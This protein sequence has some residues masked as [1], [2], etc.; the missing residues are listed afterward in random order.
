MSIRRDAADQ[1]GF[2]MLEVLIATM[3]MVTILLALATVTAQWMPNW[4]RGMARVQQLERLGIGIDRIVADL[5][6]AQFIPLNG[7]ATS[8]V[9]DGAPLSATFVRTV[10]GLNARPGLELVRLIERADRQGLA[11]VRESRSFAPGNAGE[12]GQFGN[13]VVLLRAPYRITFSYAGRDRDWQP[14]WR[15]AKELPSLIRISVRDAASDRQ[16]AASTIAAVQV[17]AAAVCVTAK[18]ISQCLATGAINDVPST[19]AR[20]P[21]SAPAGGNN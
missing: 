3:L 13:P 15:D 1:S 4:N 6:A 20:A 2:T 12:G 19:E 9:F 11:L 16:A 21:E 18:D 14:Q 5:A 8:P 7:A 17:N 10:V